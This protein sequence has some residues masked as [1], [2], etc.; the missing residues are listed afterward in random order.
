MRETALSLRTVDYYDRRP[1]HSSRQRALRHISP[2][3]RKTLK[4]RATTGSLRMAAGPSV[5]SSICRTFSLR[6][7][8]TTKQ[9]YHSSV[10]TQT[11][12]LE[13]ER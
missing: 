3:D 7:Q 6:P 12:R 5:R 11:L 2:S 9:F 10:T 1:S 4:S 13:M 8:P